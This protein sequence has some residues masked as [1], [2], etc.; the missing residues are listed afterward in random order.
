MRLSFKEQQVVDFINLTAIS[1]YFA[2][3]ITGNDAFLFLGVLLG[4][5]VFLYQCLDRLRLPYMAAISLFIVTASY[6]FTFLNNGFSHGSL[7]I[8]LYVACMGI[9]W[10]I[11]THGINYTFCW[12]VFYGSLAYFVVMLYVFNYSLW[13]LFAYSR[14]H[15]SV[16][17]INAAA[18]LYIA[19][20]TTGRKI[21][22]IPAFFVLFVSVVSI[23]FGGIISALMFFILLAYHKCFHS[24]KG[25]KVILFVVIAVVAQGMVTFWADIVNYL[26]TFSYVK[27][28]MLIK[29]QT[30]HEVSGSVRSQIWGEYFERL[31]I[32]RLLLGISLSE[33]F[34]GYANLH[35]SYFMLHA[36]MGFLALILMALFLYMLLKMYRVNFVYFVCFF[37]L[38]LRGGT[39]TTFLAG[40]S[41]DFVLLYFFLF[42]YMSFSNR[43]EVKRELKIAPNSAQHPSSIVYSIK[44]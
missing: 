44:S 31:D 43:S 2:R 10:R 5:G 38:L 6:L 26:S 7:F 29:L 11:S 19:A 18:L 25:Y 16:Y 34:Y 28:D 22:L 15:I 41:F 4:G 3:A 36:R 32:T 21:S 39:D 23:G 12:L 35:S 40:S 27:G 30:L 33:E 37:V 1:S 14:N 20:L 8:V 9:A 24:V 13:S 17:F 42:A